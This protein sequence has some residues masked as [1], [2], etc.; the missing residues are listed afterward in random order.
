MIL[1][2]EPMPIHRSH[3]SQGKKKKKEGKISVVINH[4][5]SREAQYE[6][7]NVEAA[8]STFTHDPHAASR[9]MEE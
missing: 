2:I 9:E 5:T 3:G 4:H 6:D 1:V 7:I 8:P